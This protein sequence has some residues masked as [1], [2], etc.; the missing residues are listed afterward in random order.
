MTEYPV[1]TRPSKPTDI[2]DSQR[3][4]SKGGIPRWIMRV[5]F[6][7]YRLVSPFVRAEINNSLWEDKQID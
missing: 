4:Q 1:N 3:P 6:L 7:F 2:V 5:R